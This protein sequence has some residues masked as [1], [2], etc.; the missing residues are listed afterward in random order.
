MLGYICTFFGVFTDVY[1]LFLYLSYYQFTG[2]PLKIGLSFVVFGL[3]NILMNLF[4]LSFLTRLCIG[5]ILCVIIIYNICRNMSLFMSLKSSIAFYTYLTIGELIVIPITI[6][7]AGIYDIDIFLTDTVTANWLF[8]LI[9]SRIITIILI[10]LIQKNHYKE[11]IQ[12]TKIERLLIYIP[13]LL[14]FVIT[15]ILEHYFINVEKF[16]MED[17]T[18]LLIIFAILLMAFSVIYT[19][20][21]EQSIIA[22]QQ[23]IEISELEHRNQIQY[24]YYEEKIKY[25]NEIKRIRHDLK[26]H[27]LVIRQNNEIANIDYYNKLSKIID[28][29]ENLNSGCHVFDIL[30]FDKKKVAENQNIAFNVYVLKDISSIN[31]IDERDLCSIFGNVVDNAIENA[32]VALDKNIEIRVD[33][34]NCFFYM[35]ITNTYKNSINKIDDKFI[36]TKENPNLHGLGLNSV[37][38]SLEKYEGT[39][40]INFNDNVFEVEILIP[41]IASDPNKHFKDPI[42]QKA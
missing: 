28:N 19:R 18:T 38:H 35:H 30:I 3:V 14:T 15:V 37:K 4:E 5:I 13:L 22:R 23:K 34:I 20:F 29:D 32:A 31:Y 40:E 10:K 41:I 36:T 42:I 9:V 26:N 6:L 27:L 2:G 25:D 16:D 17:M 8:T 12:I 21:L 39:M 1:V 7:S 33:V 24:L 11:Q